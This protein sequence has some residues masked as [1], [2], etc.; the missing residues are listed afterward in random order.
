MITE[1][2]SYEE[3]AK[4]FKIDWDSN[5][6][7]RLEKIMSDTSYGKYILKNIKDE[8]DFYFKPVDLKVNGNNYV[9][10]L[11]QGGVLNIKR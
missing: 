2:M 10:N 1:K 5:L 9:L 4:E 6:A 11:A 8:Q 3:I 7:D